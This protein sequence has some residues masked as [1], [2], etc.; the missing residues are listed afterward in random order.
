MKNV[1]KPLIKSVLILLGLTAAAL[2]RDA[3]IHEKMFGSGLLLDLAWRVITLII[4]IEETNC[5]MEIVQSLKDSD[6]LIK[7][8]TEAIKN[9]VK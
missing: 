2:A 6:L 4:F 3:A 5:I 1:L 8:V 7:C 9:E